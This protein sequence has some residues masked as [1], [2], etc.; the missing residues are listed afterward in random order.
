[1]HSPGEN[2]T[3]RGYNAD[4]PA[5]LPALSGAIRL[6]PV[7][8]LAPPYDDDPPADPPMPPGT[9]PACRGPAPA[10]PVPQHHTFPSQFAQ[11]LAETL[12]GA[13]P[14]GQ[15][16]KWTN[17]RA[18]ARISRLG[19]VLA[20]GRAPGAPRA[21]GQPRARAPRQ[22]VQPRVHRVVTSQP[23]DGVVEMSVVVGFGEVVRALAV[24]LERTPPQPARPGRPA[25]PARWLCTALEAG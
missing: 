25:Q 23:A 18:R 8:D 5:S 10:P 17:E 16:T 1:M 3:G 2:V 15:L 13:R 12:A 14:P 11:I 6:C 9:I 24:R 21:P 19:P 22:R 7:P 4:M 20:A